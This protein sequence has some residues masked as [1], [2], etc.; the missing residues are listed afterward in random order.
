MNRGDKKEGADHKLPWSQKKSI[1]DLEEPLLQKEVNDL[2]SW[3][4]S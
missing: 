3:V 4:L 2:V 1:A